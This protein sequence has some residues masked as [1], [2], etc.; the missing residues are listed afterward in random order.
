MLEN[1]INYEV[2]TGVLGPEAQLL[3]QK[4]VRSSHLLQ[5]VN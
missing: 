5:Y 1:K 3:G 4:N 2:V